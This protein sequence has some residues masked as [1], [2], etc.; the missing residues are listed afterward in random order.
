MTLSVEEVTQA[1]ALEVERMRPWLAEFLADHLRWWSAA[2]GRVWSTP[3]IEAHI[4]Q[5]ELVER[6]VVEM[7]EACGAKDQYVG[8]L[9]D[10]DLIGVVYAA[11]RTCRYLHVPVGVV[12]WVAVDPKRRGEGLGRSLITAARDW[13]N[14]Q[15]CQLQEVF[16]TAPNLGAVEMYRKAGF[17]VVDHR[18]L[19]PGV[20]TVPTR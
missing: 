19:A 20:Q 3:E 9:R 7:R 17:S 6:D 1:D 16:V 4:A 11:Q 12:S 2:A 18:M 13:M 10:P 5:H 14:A 15:G 8:I